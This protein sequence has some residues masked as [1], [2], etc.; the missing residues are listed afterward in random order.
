MRAVYAL[1]YSFVR[2][3]S[4]ADDLTQDVFVRAYAGIKQ[5]RGR[6]AFGTWLYRIAHNVCTNYVRRRPPSARQLGDPLPSEGGRLV[7][8]DGAPSPPEALSLQELRERADRAIGAL[9]PKLR[10][11]LELVVH[12]GMSHKDAAK[13]LGCR[14]NTVSWRVFR[15]RELLMEQL[16]G[17]VDPGAM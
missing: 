1:A 11:A 10:L 4:D 17:H 8:A 9:P 12:Q 16:A 2:N 15:A 13:V 5:F 14:P 6:A 7:P 3:H